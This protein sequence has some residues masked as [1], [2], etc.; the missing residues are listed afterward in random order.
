MKI[1]LR[2]GALLLLLLLGGLAAQAQ[3]S[4][5]TFTL[6]RTS[7]DFG[8]LRPGRSES[9]VFTLTNTGSSPLVLLDV[10]ISCNCVKVNWPRQPI[11][12]GEKAELTV[13]YKDR[14]AG[15]FYKVA[16]VV[17]NGNPRRVQLRLKGSI[18]DR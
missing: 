11:L 6:D 14:Q 4:P 3:E 17:T 5:E 16:E 13:T 18:A 1:L 2:T 8:E 15:A 10:R 12:P 7:H 9:T